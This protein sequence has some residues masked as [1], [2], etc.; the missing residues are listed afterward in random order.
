MIVPRRNHG[1]SSTSQGSGERIVT[2]F[3][4][5]MDGI[6]QKNNSKDCVFLIAV[7]SDRTS[8]DP[9]ILRPG[10]IDIHLELELP[11]QE[12]RVSFLENSLSKLPQQDI[13]E[14]REFLL[15]L[16]AKTK[17]FSNADLVMIIQKASMAAI[18]ASSHHLKQNHVIQAITP[19]QL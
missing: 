9:A 7:A 14:D 3:L 18:R 15:D 4:V 6:L 16:G 12:A 11:G 13:L 1:P 19:S 8:I 2:S 10:R 17:G 5:E